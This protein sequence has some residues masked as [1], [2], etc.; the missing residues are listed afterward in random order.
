M[1]ESSTPPPSAPEVHSFWAR[2][3]RQLFDTEQ[4]LGFA[5]SIN[6]WLS[7]LIVLSSLAVLL[8]LNPRLAQAHAEVFSWI[9]RVAVAVFTLEYL[10]R[11][12][13][14]AHA[15][16]ARRPWARL[17]WAFKP[18]ALIDLIAIAPFY[19]A[20]LLPFNAD[21]LRLLRLARLA[22]ILKLG[23]HMVEA[24][25]EFQQLNDGQTLRAKVHA[26][27]EPG[28][29]S[30]QLHRHV[31]QFIIFWIVLSI[32][33]TVVESV[34]GIRETLALEIA[35]IDTVAFALFTIEYMARWYASVEHPAFAG[36]R[37]PRWAYVRSPQAI[38]DL[39]AI[40][41]FLL[42]RFLPWPLDLRFLRVFR[43]LRLLKL[44]RYAGATGTLYRV[45][46]REKSVLFAAVFVMMLLVVLTASMGY[47]F[48]HHAQPEAF[49]NIPQTIYWA[50]ITLSSVGYGD[51]SPVTPLGRALTVILS[52]LGIGIFAIPAGLLASA[53]SDQLRLER[54]HLRQ[55]IQNKLHKGELDTAGRQWLEAEAQR[56]HLSSA[57]VQRLLAEAAA[58]ERSTS[59]AT[60]KH[61]AQLI[62]PHA[63][64]EL[65]AA[66]FQLLV[67]QLQLLRSA[68]GDGLHTQLPADSDA[69]RV[70]HTLK[71]GGHS[72]G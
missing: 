13:C 32:A 9:E 27:M 11:L 39:L 69:A 4:P 15:P 59:G 72:S 47:L 36:R 68:S 2:L 21:W 20:P 70:L 65:A 53:F 38:I 34:S 22:R 18:Y 63:H 66:Q 54:D 50:V 5:H 19:L 45:V 58:A 46:Q 12:G 71:S 6:R 8:E 33:S 42:E 3:H 48:E 30:G 62:D 37:W 55:D 61:I 41:P 35:I 10:L 7:W 67:A 40:L 29:R 51:I 43:L 49:E 52:L 57:E 1:T 28:P 14:A 17:R 23:R 31:D 25:R 26:L 60:D 16:G 24:W 64:P 44:T 56:L